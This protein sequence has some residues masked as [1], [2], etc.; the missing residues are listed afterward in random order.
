MNGSAIVRLNVGGTV[1]FV[2]SASIASIVFDGVAKTQG[3]VVSLAL[4]G[5]GAVF[6]LWGYWRAIQR[7]RQDSMSVT[8]LYFLVGPHV[9]RQVSRLMN[10]LLAVQVIVAVA[11]AVARS[12]TP[13]SDGTQTPGS[14]LAFGVLVPV[15]GLGLNG[16]WASAHGRFPPRTSSRPSD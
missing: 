15:F 10:A 11:T 16:L 2:G 4:F 12:S 7:S 6:F 14:T 5:A 3:V 13:A 8:E 9:D 1:L